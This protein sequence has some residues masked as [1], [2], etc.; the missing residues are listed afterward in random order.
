M[1]G[2]DRLDPDVIVDG[3]EDLAFNALS[4]GR[5]YLT[6]AR[7]IRAAEEGTEVEA[8]TGRCMLGLADW[9]AARVAVIIATLTAIPRS[10][11]DPRELSYATFEEA[12]EQAIGQLEVYR[13]W[14]VES[15]HIA[16]VGARRD[17]DDILSSWADEAP[18]Q[19]RQVGLVPLIENA[20]VIRDPSDVAFWVEQGVRLVGPAWHANRYS[21]DTRD[22]GPLTPLGREL[23]RELERHGLTLD[24]THMSNEACLEALDLF[25]GRVVATHAHS[26]RTHAIERLLSDEV[27]QGIFA[28][29]GIVGVLA[30]NWALVPG[31]KRGDDK[32]AVPLE[33]L[34]DAIDTVCQ[35]AGNAE[36]VALGTDFDGGQGAESAPAELDTVADLPRLASALER[37]GYRDDDVRRIMGG[38]WIRFLRSSLPD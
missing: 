33:A 18:A 5:D 3:H 9:L 11:A 15:P 28:R 38:N 17:L 25:D 36:H 6:S 8:V 7:A 12:R 14:A 29:N 13:R 23:I 2:N 20:D 31:W 34:V 27:I 1:A 30:L 21:G 22:G 19:R 10:R 32:A 26:R 35:I 16:V 24:V 4:D 37:R